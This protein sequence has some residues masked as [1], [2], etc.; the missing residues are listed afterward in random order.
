MPDLPAEQTAALLTTL[1]ANSPIGFGFVD[2][3][4][5]M[6]QINETLAAVNGATVAE[7][8]GRTISDLAPEIWPQLEPL[9][10]GVLDSGLPVRDIA[11]EGPS[12][13]DPGRPHQWLSS[14]YPVCV[15]TKIVG[16][17]LIVVD[18]SDRVDAEEVRRRL[19]TIVED[20]GDAIFSTTVDG[21]TRT[22]NKAAEALFGYCA[23]EMLDRPIAVLT[24]PRLMVERG[25][26]CERLNAGGPTERIETSMLCKDGHL[27]DVL[28]TASA[29]FDSQGAIVGVSMIV[30]D[31]T[32][33]LASEKRLLAS[34][35]RLE[36]AQRIAEIGSFEV[37]L[38][39]DTITWSDELY[40]IYGLEPSETLT[41]EGVIARVHPDDRD[42]FVTALVHTELTGEPLDITFRIVRPDSEVRWVRH[43]AV[44][45]IVDGELVKLAGTLQDTTAQL[46]DAR[47]RRD[48]EARF[49]AG[50]EQAGIGAAI[51]GLDGIPIRVNAALGAI[52]GRPGDELVGHNWDAYRTAED[53]DRGPAV[54]AR[55]AATED[56]Y[57]DE[58]RYLRPDGSLVWALLNLSLVRDDAGEPH[59]YLAQFQDITEH[60]Q[61]EGELARRA[62]QDTL[63]GLPNGALLTDRLAQSLAGTR[64]RHSQLGVIFLNIDHF[65]H[66]NDGFGPGSGDSLLREVAGRITSTIRASDT[67]ARFGGDEF[68]IL[69]LD[70]SPETTG[71]T[72]ERV[73]A[74]IRRP[75]TLA[76]EFVD[77]TASLGVAMADEGSTSLSLLRGS[78]DA[79]RRAKSLGRNRV[80]HFNQALRAKAEER[81]AITADLRHAL[82][83]E[84]LIVYYQPVIDLATGMMVSAEALLR[85]EDPDRGA[86]SPAEFIPLAEE[87]GLIV[88]IGAWVLEQACGHL[89]H[90]QRSDPSMTV[91][92]NLSVRQLQAVNIVD[93][94]EGVLR[95]SEIPPETLYLEITE[96]VF[97]QDVDDIDAM[98]AG[99]KD[100]GVQLSLD[101]FGTGYSSL[102][103]LSRYPFDA[104]K[105]DQSFVRGLGTNPH[106]TALVTAI[107]SMAEALGLS[108]TAE[109][110]EDYG[111]LSAL[112]GMRCQRAQGY[113]LDRPLPADEMT[114]LLTKSHRWLLNPAPSRST[115]AKE[116]GPAPQPRT[117]AA[118][119]PAQHEVL[120]YGDDSRLV[121]DLTAYV[122]AGLADGGH[123]LVIA[124]AEH[125]AALHADLP[126]SWLGRAEREGR[127]VGVESHRMLMQFMRN[128][129]PDPELFQ[130]SV[131]GQ[132][133]AHVTTGGGPHVYE[134]LGN[135]LRKDGNILGGLQLEWLWNELGEQT[136]LDLLCG[137]ALADLP[138][139]P[140]GSVTDLCHQHTK[141]HLGRHTIAGGEQSVDVAQVLLE[142]TRA[143]LRISST[144]QAVGTLMRA[145]AQLGGSCI[146]AEQDTGT[147]IP[148]DINLG[149]AAALL[150]TAPA[151]SRARRTIE[152]VLPALVDDALRALSL[153]ESTYRMSEHRDT[154]ALTGLGNRR[155]LGDLPKLIKADT[156][157]MVD[158][159]RFAAVNQKYGRETGDRLLVAFSRMVRQRLRSTDLVFRLRGAEVLLVLPDTEPH[160]ALIVLEQMRLKWNG[161]RPLPVT[162]SAGVARIE[163]GDLD[164]AIRTAEGALYAAKAHGRDRFEIVA[165]GAERDAAEWLRYQTS[166]SDL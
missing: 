49:E 118:H 26:M 30:Q 157:A 132:V 129:V 55:M 16:I 111:Q 69:C 38:V 161:E 59:Y 94:V 66:V 71:R 80:E 22:W 11:V 50:F 10:Q 47:H 36:E 14:F 92:V 72:A 24:P 9:Y 126:R 61:M 64:Q 150:P 138:A 32:E 53:A 44:A 119:R 145:V 7:Q 81:L 148:I 88:P 117:D 98:L 79:M 40:R 144:E 141:V 158:L 27:V 93:L 68:V 2:R 115:V 86:I 124:S 57:T 109:G 46:A 165:D 87:T 136:T 51:L 131:G 29:S 48:A 4:F 45:E 140:G 100:L 120:F 35:Q 155:R 162:F 112:M 123:A 15:G 116:T 133:R 21:M 128:G 154:D 3:D 70:A 139:D 159:D 104:I 17:A 1:Q 78:G 84:Q 156:I 76:D 121:R 134:E 18:V 54:R 42:L 31:I 108:V 106:D 56:S 153:S 62:L 96:S 125:L 13:A 164:T 41:R 166:E 91:A 52:L 130:Q 82:D 149:H 5:R 20:S 122:A 146:P 114:G 107:M 85:W 28:V 58:R 23:E 63:T 103:Y 8:I 34:Q 105:I 19:A 151:G 95:R 25:Q 97:G 99:L 147:A 73:L 163:D 67:V 102:S 90:W 142:S 75:F 43:L 135:Q 137:Y 77:V 74:A 113:Y 110:I 33:R 101:D 12:A 6:L 83:R 60:K 160:S 37:E 143:L 89:R 39:N 127:F 152:R 65:K